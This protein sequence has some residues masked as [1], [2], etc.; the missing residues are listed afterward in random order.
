MTCPSRRLA[1]SKPT[2]E[3]LQLPNHPTPHD[4][5]NDLGGASPDVLVP[6]EQGG[7][8]AG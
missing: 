8:E 4:S 6:I 2:R 3:R 7:G 5:V 1:C